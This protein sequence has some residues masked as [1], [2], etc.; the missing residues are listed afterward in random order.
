MSDDYISDAITRHPGKHTYQKYP[1]LSPN[2][3]DDAITRHPGLRT[4]IRSVG[5][6]PA[7]QIFAGR[8]QSER[9]GMEGGR[10]GCSLESTRG[11]LDGDHGCGKLG[12][13]W[14]RFSQEG[15]AFRPPRSKSGVNQV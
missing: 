15:R 12:M 5:A 14:G 1:N 7:S 2:Q 10:A 11:N 13:A 8:P 6:S 3:R 4:Q 9:E